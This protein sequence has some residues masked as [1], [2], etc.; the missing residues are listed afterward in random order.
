MNLLLMLFLIFYLMQ[1]HSF[2]EPDIFNYSFLVQDKILNSIFEFS[3]VISVPL[4]F[5]VI[6]ITYDFTWNIKANKINIIFVKL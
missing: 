3:L 5:N 1:W 6:E 2:H 4:L